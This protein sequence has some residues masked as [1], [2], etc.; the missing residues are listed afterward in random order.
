MITTQEMTSTI[1]EVDFAGFTTGND[2]E[3]TA[4]ANQIGEA[5]SSSGS[6]MLINHGIAELLI[7]KSFYWV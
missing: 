2:S 5:L 1:P 4:I 3:R 6:F 7:Q